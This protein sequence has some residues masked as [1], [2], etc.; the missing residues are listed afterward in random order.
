[1]SVY[2]RY[3]NTFN[4]VDDIF[5]KK[6][7]TLVQY[8]REMDARLFAKL[9]KMHTFFHT[10]FKGQRGIETTTEH[11]LYENIIRCTRELFYFQIKLQYNLVQKN[12]LLGMMIAS[13]FLAS[14]SILEYDYCEYVPFLQDLEYFGSNKYTSREILKMEFKLFANTNYCTD[15]KVY[16]RLFGR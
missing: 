1:M 5:I 11:N 3:I 12:K 13:Y 9:N 7:G 14:K 16:N 2:K 4:E 10:S 8:T 15:V 6:N